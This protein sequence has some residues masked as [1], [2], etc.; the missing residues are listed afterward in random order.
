MRGRKKIICISCQ[1]D[2]LHFGLDMCSAC[3]RNHKRKTRPSFYLGTCYSEITRRCTK[4][5]QI[6]PNYFGKQ[7]CTK[8]QFMD[9]FL[10]DSKFLELYSIWQNNK[11]IRKYAP[12]IDRIDNNKD[13]TIDNL[14]FTTHYENSTKDNKLPVR[15]FENGLLIKEFDSQLE[16]AKY[17]NVC[18]AVICNCIKQFK[19][20]KKRYNV[21]RV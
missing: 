10:N 3:L 2:K 20:I 16:C 7:K 9:K 14:R 17:L 5:D 19:R 13:Y 4:F 8:I 18:P 21:I 1:K 15:L 11:Y 6:R 12:S